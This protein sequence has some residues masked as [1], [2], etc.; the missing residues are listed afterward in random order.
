ML[1]KSMQFEDATKC[2]HET[3]E[4]PISC[5]DKQLGSNLGFT[6]WDDNN[7]SYSLTPVFKKDI[8]IISKDVIL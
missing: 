5:L 3:H 7:E 2:I 1:N 4:K 6:I 8:S